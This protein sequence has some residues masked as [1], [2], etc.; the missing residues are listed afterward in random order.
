MIVS[1]ILITGGYGFIG[2][3]IVRFLLQNTQDLVIN[4]DK[5]TYAANLLALRDVSNNPRYIFGKVD[6]C[7]RKSLKAVFERYQPEQVLHLAAESHVD[8]SIIGAADFIHTNI[9]GT[10][11]L[12]E[13]AKEHWDSLDTTQKSA[14][15]FHHV[16]TDEVYGDLPASEPPVIESA[17]Y[18]PS[19]PYSASKAA[20]DHLVRAWYRTYGLPIIVT[21]STNNYGPYQNSE[22]LIPSIISNALIGKPLTI[23]G[24]GKQIRDWLFVDDHVQA[25]YQVLTKGRIGES[26]NIGGNCEKTNCEV[27]HKI[28]ELLEELAPV[29]VNNIKRYTDLIVYVKDRPG[30][31]MRYALDCSKINNELGWRPQISFTQGI[32]QTVKWYLENGGIL[33]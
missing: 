27:V 6:I 4:I 30:H 7:D 1:R 31:D 11:T 18:R 21:N 9:L 12:L 19:N 2:S 10:Y 13:V 32:R 29:K 20:S 28:C 26:Y 3:A 17:P 25:L 15:R 5:M 16:S 24:D 22:K 8:R 33:K 23:Y 14:F